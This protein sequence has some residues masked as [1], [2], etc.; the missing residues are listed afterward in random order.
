MLVPVQTSGSKPPLF[1]I[2]GVRGFMFDLGPKF[3]RM[4]GPDQPMYVINANGID[5]RQPIVES[6][7][8]M[9]IAYL[10]EIR[11][12]QSTGPVRIGGMCSGC[13]VA[14]EI[15]RALQ[16]DGRPTGPVMLVDPPVLTAAYQKRSKVSPEAQDRF[17][18]EVFSW[19]VEKK[20]NADGRE[21]DL[22]FDPRDS[23][24]LHL[25]TVI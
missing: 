8:E 18:K 10:Q 3:A 13:M 25:A 20:L 2:H 5:G 6:V 14:I 12:A 11:G 7:P 24:Q 21:K 22:P 16:E 19:F 9:V 1:F 4:L 17:G 23:K 15:A